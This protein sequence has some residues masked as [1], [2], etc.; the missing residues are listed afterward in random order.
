MA[1][2]MLVLPAPVG[3]TRANRSAPV[4]VDRRCGSRNAVKPSSS[5]R[6]GL[7]STP[8]PSL[9]DAARRTAR[10]DR[11]RSS[12]TSRSA[13][14]SANS[15]WGVRPARLAVDGAPRVLDVA[16]RASTTST[17]AGNALAHLVGQARPGGLVD[18]EPQVVVAGRC[19]RGRRA[20][21]ACPAAC[22]AGGRR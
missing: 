16:R 6:T 12:A 10:V 14:Y 11:R 9:V 2:M 20:R 19:R 22:A 3:P 1:S 15:S 17:A 13:R 18:H 8:P 5:S 4:E 21:R 7:T